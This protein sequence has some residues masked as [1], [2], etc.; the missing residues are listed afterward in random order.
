M[1]SRSDLYWDLVQ[2]LIER[3]IATLNEWYN[4]DPT[5]YM[6]FSRRNG[7]GFRPRQIMHD[8]VTHMGW[9]KTLYDY[10]LLSGTVEHPL[11]NSVY[12]LFRDNG[13][14]PVVVG[15]FLLSWCK[16]E[17]GQNTVWVRGDAQ[18]G[19]RSLGE[20]LSYLGP[21]RGVA[22]CHDPYNPFYS[23]QSKLVIWWD[24]GYPRESNL[25][26]CKQVFGGHHVIIPARRSW[27]LFRTPVVIYSREDICRVRGAGGVYH[28]DECGGLRELMYPLNLHV[29]LPKDKEYISTHALRQFLSWV[30]KRDNEN[31]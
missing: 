14:D 20:A 1:S 21:L 7:P 15:R 16:G 23:C 30:D 2:S 18:S 3:G 19:A 11:R 29:P 22:D 12:H 25:D 31:Q 6:Y 24:N 17:S 26:L 27:E 9:Q 13:Y 8:V 4:R 10:A 5:E 28:S